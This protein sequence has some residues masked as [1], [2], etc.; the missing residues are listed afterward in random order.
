MSRRVRGILGVLTLGP[1]SF[2][3]GIAAATF[4]PEVVFYPGGVPAFDVEGAIT[5]TAL[6]FFGIGG[7][8][9]G[10]FAILGSDRYF[11]ARE[12]DS[13]RELKGRRRCR[14]ER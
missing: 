10:C 13:K 7:I 6:M 12:R 4:F 2:L 11:S 1:G 14:G 5:L 8:L 3:V 9:A